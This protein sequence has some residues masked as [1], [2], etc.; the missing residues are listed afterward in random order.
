MKNWSGNAELSNVPCRSSR[1]STWILALAILA[2]LFSYIALLPIVSVKLCD[3]N[4]IPLM[5][6]SCCKSVIVFVKFLCDVTT[7]LGRNLAIRSLSKR[8]ERRRECQAA[9]QLQFQVPCSVIS[10]HGCPG[11]KSS[12]DSKSVVAFRVIAIGR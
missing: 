12:G 8:R 4:V 2:F 7:K 9:R 3:T 10:A 5:K 6:P 11:F 1:G